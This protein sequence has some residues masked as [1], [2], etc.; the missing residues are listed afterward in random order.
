MGQYFMRLEVWPGKITICQASWSQARGL[1]QL[2]ATLLLSS[3]PS[4]AVL[5]SPCPISPFPPLKAL[6][7]SLLKNTKQVNQDDIKEISLHP[8]FLCSG[9][10]GFPYFT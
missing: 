1:P 4:R 6:F 9:Q 5:H 8:S 10:P 7:N 3:D 2:T